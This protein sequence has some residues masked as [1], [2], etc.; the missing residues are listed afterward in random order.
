M[1]EVLTKLEG[2]ALYPIVS[3]PS[4]QECGAAR[5]VLFLGA[6]SIS[7]RAPERRAFDGGDAAGLRLKPPKSR[8]GRRI[9]SLPAGVVEVLREHR[10]RQMQE[11][12]LLGQGRAEDDDLVFKL[13]DGSPY[14]PDTL[15]RDWGNVVRLAKVAVRDVPLLAPFARQRAHRGGSR[16][17]GGRQQAHRPRQPGHYALGLRPLVPRQG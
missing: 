1:A 5:Y 3:L 6:R 2:H 8:A 4:A 13:V 9:V 16:R 14:P 17:G 10:R 11:R 12:L 7:T 15:S